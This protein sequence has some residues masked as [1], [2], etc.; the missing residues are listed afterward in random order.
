MLYSGLKLKIYKNTNRI[1]PYIINRL[2]RLN[3]GKGLAMYTALS[4]I[5]ENNRSG[6]YVDYRILIIF[7]ENNPLGWGLLLKRK[8][9]KCYEIMIYVAKK[10]RRRGIGT[11]LLNKMIKINNNE[12]PYVYMHDDI[13]KGF[14]KNNGYKN[15]KNRC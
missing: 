13:S 3:F 4:D 8:H 1:S 12:Y 7:K 11:K 5:L 9:G 14:Y 15:N 2:K 10:H 6:D